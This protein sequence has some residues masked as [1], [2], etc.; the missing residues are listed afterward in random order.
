MNDLEPVFHQFPCTNILPPIH[1][2]KTV[3]DWFKG[4]LSFGTYSQFNS[5]G[6]EFVWSP[7]DNVGGSYI[8]DTQGAVA[9]LL[10]S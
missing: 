3:W 6:L 9:F 8:R 7:D 5:R 2:I 10:H 4:A 1:W